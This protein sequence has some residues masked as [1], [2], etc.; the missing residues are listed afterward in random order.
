MFYE[1]PAQMSADERLDELAARLVAAGLTFGA[2]AQA[3]RRAF[4]PGR[5]RATGY[6]H[7]GCQHS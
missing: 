5:G 3:E 7:T 6:Q 2:S 1:D 4:P